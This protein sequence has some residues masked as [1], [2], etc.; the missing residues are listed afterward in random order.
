[1]WRVVVSLSVRISDGT[2]YLSRIFH[3]VGWLGLAI[4]AATVDPGAASIEADEQQPLKEDRP[5]RSSSDLTTSVR[6][7]TEATEKRPDEEP[8]H[9]E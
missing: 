6:E 7:S 1:M 2:D 8:G 4:P 5:P 3:K 9:P